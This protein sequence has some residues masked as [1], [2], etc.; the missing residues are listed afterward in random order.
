MKKLGLSLLLCLSL[1]AWADDDHDDEFCGFKAPD[2]YVFEHDFDDCDDL[3]L[4]PVTPV[5]QIGYA[6]KS[7][8]IVI[9]PKF[10]EAYTF[11]EGLALV[12]QNDKYGYL[13]P[14]GDFAIK[15]IFD[16][17]WGFS[18]GLAKIEQNGKYGFIDK[19]GK[20]VIKPIYEDTDNWFDEGLVV[21]QKD[22]KWG[23]IDKQGKTKIAFEYDIMDKFSEGLALVAKQVGVDD[24]GDE[25][26][27]YGFIN[28][29]G[30]IVIGLNYEYATGFD[31]GVATVYQGGD[32]HRI[33]KTGKIIPEKDDK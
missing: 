3:T 29:A 14:K 11:Q 27:R 28:N 1:T 12:K 7:G 9:A 13:N 33:D 24:D 5:S 25:I 19:T 22:K 2:G 16:D 21:A 23:M 6:D 31:D 20:I 4:V 30:K 26:Y 32:Y 15:P 8:K 10:E 18:E 17:A